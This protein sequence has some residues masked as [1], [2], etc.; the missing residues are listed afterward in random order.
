MKIVS[1]VPALALAA[2]SRNLTL[3]FSVPAQ[4]QLLQ[5]KS[6]QIGRV[7]V[8]MS[9]MGESY[10]VP[11]WLYDNPS[12]PK[13]FTLAGLWPDEPRAE[14]IS[15]LTSLQGELVDTDEWDDRV[16]HVIYYANPT[17]EG[18]P[19]KVM[20]AIAA[21]RFVVTKVGSRESGVDW[22]HVLSSRGLWTKASVTE[23]SCRPS[24]RTSLPVT[25]W[26]RAGGDTTRVR[27]GSGECSRG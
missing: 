25:L 23:P 1:S 11:P 10:Q 12:L 4:Y 18:L 19:E 22:S 20:G 8:W 21:G 27:P 9:V 2:Y 24:L 16:T 14:V 17:T 15:R 13:R 3:L 5:V 7:S 6:L 26:T